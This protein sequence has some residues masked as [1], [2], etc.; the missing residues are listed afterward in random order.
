MAGGPSTTRLAAAVSEAGGL[1]SVAGAVLSPDELE[2]EIR[3]MRALTTKPFAVNLFAPL[4]PPSADRVAEWAAYLGSELEL[5]APQGWSF[6]DQLAVLAAAEVRILSFT[7]GIPPLNGFDAITIG[8]ATTVEEAVALEQAGFDVVVTQGFE[9]G[10]HRGTFLTQPDRAIVGNLA[11]VPQ[12]VDAVSVPVVAAGGIM[13]GRAVAA[14]LALG[15]QGVQLGTAFIGCPESGATEEHRSAL[16]DETCLTPVFT[17]RHAR[18]VRTP[19]VAELERSGLEPPDF[20]L[21]RYLFPEPV[22]LAGQGGA[23]ARALPAPELVRTLA[24]ETE[25]ALD[26]ARHGQGAT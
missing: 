25:A 8:T 6:A 11:L 22:H 19:I 20:P 2:A 1:G 3:E 26:R 24:S 17:G 15:A 18:G 5:P 7:F 14:A 12:V 10:G 4:P 16:G 13:D 23:L 9:A 21:A